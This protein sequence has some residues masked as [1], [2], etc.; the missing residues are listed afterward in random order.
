MVDR[1][2]VGRV[3][4][5]EQLISLAIEFPNAIRRETLWARIASV[6]EAGP[7]KGIGA[8]FLFSDGDQRDRIAELVAILRAKGS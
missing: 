1:H 2:D 6:I 4:E 7:Q 8:E 3:L 5:K